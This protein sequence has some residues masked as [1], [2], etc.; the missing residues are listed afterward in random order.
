MVPARSFSP[1]RSIGRTGFVATALGAGDVADPDM[2]FEDCVATLRRA[3]D[4]G[5]N[6]VDTAPNYADGLSERI[7]G[8]AIRDRRDQVFLIDKIDH[9]D[10][11]VAPQVE[12][13]LTRLGLERA[14]L[15]V[16]HALKSL[17]EW[18]ALTAPGGG[19]DQLARCVAA[20]QARFR[21]ISCHHPDVLLAAIPS[22]LCD[23]VMFPIGPWVDRRYLD[24][25]L[26]LA[27][28]AGIGTITFK[29]FGAGKLVA[30]TSGYGQPWSAPPGATA[31]PRLSV[32]EC[33]A[34]TLTYDPDVALLGMSTPAEQDAAFEAARTIAPLAAADLEGIRLRARAAIA[35]KGPCWWDPDP[36]RDGR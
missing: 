17:D 25:V 19:F 12:G 18:R 23:V 3:L 21:G 4:R 27:R 30:E 11:P 14:D 5:L 8:A 28:R 33:L 13:S 29:T 6:V 32:D 16:F 15:F 1:R 36:V 35:G 10:A 9:L 34:F 7:V 26:P 22:G 24:E 20:G 2:P 31:P